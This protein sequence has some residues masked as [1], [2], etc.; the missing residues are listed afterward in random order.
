[1]ASAACCPD[2]S[3][4]LLAKSAWEAAKFL[5][6]ES[7]TSATPGVEG[8][9]DPPCEQDVHFELDKSNTMN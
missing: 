7:M 1:M 4:D 6:M 3:R 8:K 2:G 9:F 5:P